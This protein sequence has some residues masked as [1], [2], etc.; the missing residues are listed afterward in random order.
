MLIK[1]W[2]ELHWN[3]NSGVNLKTKHVMTL[4][5]FDATVEKTVMISIVNYGKDKKVVKVSWTFTIEQIRLTAQADLLQMRCFYC[6]PNF[7][8]GCQAEDI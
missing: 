3:V 4:F 1:E 6:S 7:A 5:F 8:N 2:S